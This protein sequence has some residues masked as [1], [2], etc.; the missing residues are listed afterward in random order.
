MFGSGWTTG[1]EE[2]SEYVPGLWVRML[3]RVCV[4]QPRGT[5]VFIVGSACSGLWAKLPTRLHG[6]CD[7]RA[8]GVNVE[9]GGG[10]RQRPHGVSRDDLGFWL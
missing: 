8:A 2:K 6:R 10:G 1:A 5:R 9:G 3:Y 7:L 4:V